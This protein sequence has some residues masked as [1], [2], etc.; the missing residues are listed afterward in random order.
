MLVHCGCLGGGETMP[1]VRM[2]GNGSQ[3]LIMSKLLFELFSSR[4]VLT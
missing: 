3:M 4:A 1:V 2:E